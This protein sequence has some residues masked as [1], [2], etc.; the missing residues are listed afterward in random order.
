MIRTAKRNDLFERVEKEL[1]NSINKT[2]PAMQLYFPQYA[3]Y[4][5]RF[6][7]QL[8][9]SAWCEK[10][11]ITDGQ[12][13]D[14]AMAD[15]L[16]MSGICFAA[17]TDTQRVHALFEHATALLPRVKEV[18]Q[19]LWLTIRMLGVTELPQP[20]SP[21]LFKQLLSDMYRTQESNLQ[22][23][24]ENFALEFLCK[25]AEFDGALSF[26]NRPNKPDVVLIRYTTILD[27]VIERKFGQE[28]SK[29][30]FGGQQSVPATVGVHPEAVVQ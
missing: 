19:R 14:F 7:G 27:A 28:S 1:T 4:L 15:H 23:E 3:L 20:P 8:V 29:W 26:A 6:R 12:G 2:G 18:N 22:G 16:T 9:A 13:D 25:N 10:L 24:A 30:G 17:I 21:E 5:Q 11:G